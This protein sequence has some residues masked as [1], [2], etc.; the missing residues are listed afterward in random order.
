MSRRIIRRAEVK[1]RTSLSFVHIWRLEKRNEFPARVQLGPNSVGWYEDEVDAWVASRIRA[2]G[3]A[4]RRAT[5]VIIIVVM[6][7]VTAAARGTPLSIAS[8]GSA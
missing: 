1:R 5:A 3:R 2:G 4:V 7:A 8:W 6:V